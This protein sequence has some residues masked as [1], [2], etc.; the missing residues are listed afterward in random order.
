MAGETA[1]TAWSDDG[2]PG[3]PFGPGGRD[4]TGPQQLIDAMSRALAE[5]GAGT[6]TALASE[7]DSGTVV[8]WVRI[9]D[10]NARPSLATDLRIEL[11]SDGGSWFVVRVESRT[12]CSEPLEAA[13][14][15]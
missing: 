8:G 5:G 2:Q 7:T 12:H 4:W 15:R 13:A 14:C 6:R 11:R 3:A 1:T 10:P 9:T